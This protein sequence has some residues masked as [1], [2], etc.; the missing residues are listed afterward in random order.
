MP[1]AFTGAVGHGRN[2]RHAYAGGGT[3]TIY[4]VT[5]LN[6]SGAGSIVAAVEATGNRVVIPEVSGRVNIGRKLKVGGGNLHIAGQTGPAPGL[7]LYDTHF[8]TNSKSNIFVEHI[9]I[10]GRLGQTS[11]FDGLWCFG[12]SGAYFKNVSFLWPEDEPISIANSSYITL[13]RCLIEGKKSTSS[14]DHWGSVYGWQQT[15]PDQSHPCTFITTYKC[16]YVN[17]N[18]RNP[19]IT[20]GSSVE[21]INTFWV[22]NGDGGDCSGLIGT[23]FPGD[24]G[25]ILADFIECAYIIGPESSSSQKPIRKYNEG[26]TSGSQIYVLNTLHTDSIS[27]PTAGTRQ[28]TGSGSAWD[29]VNNTQIPSGTYQAGSAQVSSGITADS[30]A[31]AYADVITDGNVGCR[32]ADRDNLSLEPETRILGE[33]RDP[34]TAVHKTDA[35][36]TIPSYAQNILSFTIPASPHVDSGSGYTNLE[37]ALDTARALVEPQDA[38]GQSSGTPASP[39]ASPTVTITTGTQGSNVQTH[40]IPLP[41]TVAAGSQI[42]ILFGMDDGGGTGASWDQ[43]TAGTW[44][45]SSDQTGAAALYWAKKICDG[46]EGGKT[47][48]ITT[49]N[50]EKSGYVLFYSDDCNTTTPLE[51]G[52]VATGTSSAP[53]SSS[54]TFS[55]GDGNNLFITG[56]VMDTSSNGTVSGFPSGYSQTGYV[57]PSGTGSITMGYGVKSSSSATEDAGA[58]TTAESDDWIAIPAV[59]PPS[60]SVDEE[61]EPPAADTSFPRR[62]WQCAMGA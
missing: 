54:L 42:A 62:L 27:S 46:T 9:R 38:T 60:A 57:T 25:A 22:N 40:P 14:T 20:T 8:E 53:N 43:S 4:T 31:D 15:N 48:N 12:T 50:F 52:T 36:L 3:P 35:N 58:F 1:L 56:F 26:L 33:A 13:D 45:V 24:S 16:L 17:C 37:V 11:N 19:K 34:S 30:V 49:T 55:G 10:M 23:K 47:L 18:A 28:S 51:F 39:G 61:V 32:P 29:V 21:H 59:F 7:T 41:A 2:T 44:T 5:N 6:D